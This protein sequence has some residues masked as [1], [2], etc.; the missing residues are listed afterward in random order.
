[1]IK[2]FHI[3]CLFSLTVYENNSF[4][5]QNGFIISAHDDDSSLFQLVVYLFEVQWFLEKVFFLFFIC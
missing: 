5:Q 2:C 3:F 4:T 1:M